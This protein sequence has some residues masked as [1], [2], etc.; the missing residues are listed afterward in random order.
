MLLQL[1]EFSGIYL[2]ASG[3]NQVVQHIQVFAARGSERGELL[4]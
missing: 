1:M 4:R 3:R 2:F